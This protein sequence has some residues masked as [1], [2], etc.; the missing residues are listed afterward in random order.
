MRI[1]D[2][3]T[4][5]V[6]SIEAGITIRQAAEM[7]RK[8]HVGALVITQPPNG[9]RVPTGFLTD[10]DIVIS[11]VAAGIN[12]EALTVGDIVSQD[13]ATCTESEGVF[14]AIQTM[15]RR[16]VRRLPVLNGKGGLVGMLT[17]DDIYSALGTLT[18]DLNAAL[19]REQ[20]HEM[21]SRT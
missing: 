4:R 5:Q 14:D 19:T 17:A 2:I 13:L 18:H 1:A 21:T 8:H 7:M 20:V 16:S 15:R 10:R 3:C 11:V 12:T 6:I 9:E